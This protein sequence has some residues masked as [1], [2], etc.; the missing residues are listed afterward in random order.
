MRYGGDSLLIQVCDN[1]QQPVPANSTGSTGYGLIGMRERAR[2][3]GGV[4]T[5][6]PRPQGGFEVE[7]NLPIPAG[8]TD[9][10]L[11]LPD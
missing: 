4:L 8:S 1:G 3:F 11:S 5:T 6:G 9:S 7:L 10:R 2:I